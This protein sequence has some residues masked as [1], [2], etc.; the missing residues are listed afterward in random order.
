[1]YIQFAINRLTK[2][3]WSEPLRVVPE[4]ATA[5]ALILSELVTNSAKHA[6]A[7]RAEGRLDVLLRG[8]GETNGRPLVR[9]QFRDDG[10]GW[11]ED[12]LSG[13][14][15]HVGMHLIQASVRSPLRHANLVKA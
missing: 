14:S 4:Q 8:E 12:V 3:Q 10:P 11:P 13:Q 6:F 1:M 7:N 5:I 9:L 15:R 2:W